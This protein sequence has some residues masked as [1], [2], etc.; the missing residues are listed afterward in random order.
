[1]N[2]NMEVSISLDVADVEF[3]LCALEDIT[4]GLCDGPL[5]WSLL[6]ISGSNPQKKAT[7][8]KSQWMEENYTAVCGAVKMA[9]SVANIAHLYLE[10]LDMH[11]AAC[12][13]CTSPFSLNNKRASALQEG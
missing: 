3:M 5:S 11:R 7:E 1:M 12:E 4:S 13:T 8:N 6:G 9:A 10:S 2:Q